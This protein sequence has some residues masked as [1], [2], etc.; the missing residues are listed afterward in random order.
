MSTLLTPIITQL[1]LDRDRFKELIN[2]DEN[3]TVTLEGRTEKSIAGQVIERIDFVASDFITAKDEALQAATDAGI[4]RDQAQ[5]FRDEAEGFKIDA[6]SALVTTEG[7]RDQTQSIKADIDQI[8]SDTGIL[9][10]DTQSLHDATLTY[11]N[12]AQQARLDAQQAEDNAAASESNAAISASAAQ[13]SETVISSIV[14]DAQA[15]ATA[16]GQDA[17]RAEDAANGIIGTITTRL[18]KPPILV[19]P[20]T[21][22]VVGEGTIPF[23]VSYPI[24]YGNS[25][26]WGGRRIQVDKFDGSVWNQVQEYTTTSL[27]FETPQNSP[28]NPNNE[29]DV[30]DYRFRVKDEFSPLEGQGTPYSSEWTDYVE[31]TVSAA[32]T[33]PLPAPSVTTS[34]VGDS[35][36]IEATTSETVQSVFWVI[37]D[38]RSSRV[39]Y[40][41]EGQSSSSLEK[42]FPYARMIGGASYTAQC[43][44][45]NDNDEV[46]EWSGQV[47]FSKPSK[48]GYVRDFSNFKGTPTYGLVDARQAEEFVFDNSASGDDVTINIINMTPSPKWITIVGGTGSV[49]FTS[50]LTEYTPINI[51]STFTRIR[52]VDTPDGVYLIE[53]MS[54]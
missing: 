13:S 5:G 36:V 32:G 22:E 46:S 14:T 43:R 3:A 45:V 47:T 9:K 24:F 23:V 49:S 8:Y 51:G 39:E 54:V 1:E 10:N 21:G 48:V 38:K 52:V 11:R 19:Y 33:Q 7:A 18:A 15:A 25:V 30:G 44:I 35:E 17:D 12:D 4:A 2:G 16:A 53:E 34:S 41:T 27:S 28:G 37:Y 29:F 50:S 42:D 20:T 31:F 26:K 6:N 40:I